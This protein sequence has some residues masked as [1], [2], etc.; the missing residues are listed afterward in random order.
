MR[1]FVISARER[2]ADGTLLPIMGRAQLLDA[3][4]QRN[5]HPETPSGLRL[6]GPGVTIDLPEEG[7]PTQLL[8]T[9]DD[10][11]IAWV[12]IGRLTR[13]LPIR[14]LNLETNQELGAPRQD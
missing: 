7:D 11:D 14:I 10:E 12:Y 4:A 6:Y 9:I 2:P 1:Q 8:M 3:L 13:A 5:T